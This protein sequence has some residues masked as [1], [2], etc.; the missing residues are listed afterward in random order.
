MHMIYKDTT[1]VLYVIQKVE[2]FYTFLDTIYHFSEITESSSL[3]YFNTYNDD[4][5]VGK[6]K[7]L[8]F[9]L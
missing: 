5:S 4:F 6:L 1:D 9:S 7:S 3:R 2:N 8:L